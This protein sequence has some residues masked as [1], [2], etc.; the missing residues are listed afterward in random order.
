MVD[1]ESKG[2]DAGLYLCS[3]T[4]N[5]VLYVWDAKG[6][7]QEGFHHIPA[8]SQGDKTSKS[9]H[10]TIRSVGSDRVI[11]SGSG[12]VLFLFQVNG[13]S[14]FQR[15][16]GPFQHRLEIFNIAIMGNAV[17]TVSK[18]RNLIHWDIE[19][20]ESKMMIPTCGGWIYDISISPTDPSR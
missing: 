2:K 10:C 15:F 19:K 20:L 14:N 5:K 7:R 8:P 11:V 6:G 4:C 12:G 13:T 9:C 16:S 17:F 1:E 18:D 3:C